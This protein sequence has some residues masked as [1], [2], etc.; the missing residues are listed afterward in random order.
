MRS[1]GLGLGFNPNQQAAAAAPG[2]FDGATLL[3]DPSG[4]ELGAM[5]T[6]ANQGSVVCDITQASTGIV[7]DD[8]GPNTSI[9]YAKNPNGSFA[10][11]LTVAGKTLADFF[12]AGGGTIVAVLKSDATEVWLRDVTSGGLAND[13]LRITIGADTV[14]FNLVD[15]GGNKTISAAYTA[16]A[17]RAFVMRWDGTNI[18]LKGN[19][20]DWITPV[21][22]GSAADLTGVLRFDGD[23]AASIQGGC[24]LLVFWDSDIGEAA[25]DTAL[26]EATIRIT[27]P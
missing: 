25:A 5:G 10:D 17:A 20:G 6:V 18:H 3:F 22:C 2:P 27:A 9:L 26:T 21:L 16:N 23:G 1:L 4:E 13:K 15:S 8:D 7:I 11:Y 14:V 12:S 24:W 19:G